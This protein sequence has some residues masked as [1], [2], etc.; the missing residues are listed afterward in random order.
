MA[1]GAAPPTLDPQVLEQLV[2]RALDEIGATLNATLER[3]VRE[4]LLSVAHASPQPARHGIEFRV[5][6]PLEAV[7]DGRI[8]ELGPTKQKALLALLLLH[9]GRTVAVGRI[10]DELWGDDPPASA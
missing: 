2:S 9:P 8:V 10:V 7:H 1:D 5:L 6:G 4:A 3:C